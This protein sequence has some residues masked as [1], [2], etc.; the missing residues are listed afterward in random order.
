MSLFRHLLTHYSSNREA[1]YRAQ[2]VVYFALVEILISTSYYL[3]HPHF[4]FRVPRMVFSGL[5]ITVLVQIFLLRLPIPLTVIA[6]SL[7]ATLWISFCLG[8][9]TSGGI[10]SLVLPW[11]AVMPVMAN[12]LI[13]Q[14]AATIWAVISLSSILIFF[15]GGSPPGAIENSHWRSLA[16][17]SGLVVIVFVFTCLFHLTHA[18]LLAKVNSKNKKL[19][20]R[21]NR[22]IAQHREIE[23][24]KYFI[25]KQN[26]LL[27]SQNRSIEKINQLLQERVQEI[28]TRNEI[29][30]KHWQTLLTITKSYTINF[31]QL[32]EALAYITQTV[33]KS[34]NIDRVSIWRYH[35]D[36][37]KIVCLQITDV[38]HQNLKPEVDLTLEEFPEYYKALMLEQVIPAVNAQIHWQTRE[39][40]EKYLVPRNIVSMMDSPYF[41]SGKLGGVICCEH[42]QQKNWANEDILFV[43]ALSD[44]VTLSIM[45]QERRNYEAALLEKQAE[46]IQVNQSLEMRVLQRTE[47]LEKQNNRL[48]EYAYINSHLLRAPLSR[49]LGLVNLVRYSE[50]AGAEREHIIQ[51]IQVAGR[52]LDEVVAKIN[53]ALGFNRTLDRSI[54]S[55][56]KADQ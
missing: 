56:N 5:S 26:Q 30:G 43:Q 25:E 46:I 22:L 53:E 3:V 27:H 42:R 19:E 47:E 48:A 14:R 29:L 34:L 50:V 36:A 8:I 40:K 51:Q 16:A 12:L 49:L 44:I 11:L 2:L 10:L 21:K 13:N 32:K 28:M 52:E 15:L 54:F 39:L 35:P 45:T 31:G 33:N 37:H 55:D 24:Q 4:E 23:A 7:I 38:L 20:T 9:A 18:S 1:Y 6:H 17:N 41:I